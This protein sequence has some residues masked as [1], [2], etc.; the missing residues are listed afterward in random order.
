MDPSTYIQ[1][2]VDTFGSILYSV[3]PTLIVN[4]DP[5]RYLLHLVNI[6][7]G[8]AAIGQNNVSNNANTLII[9]QPNTTY[10]LILSYHGSL[11]ARALWVWGSGPGSVLNWFASSWLER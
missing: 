11:L 2:Y 5:N 9:L 7:S 3:N 10:D 6:G 1:N 8:T 4:Q